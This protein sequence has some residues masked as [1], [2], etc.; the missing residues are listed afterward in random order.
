MKKLNAYYVI[1][2]VTLAFMFLILLRTLQAIGWFQD[3]EQP[4]LMRQVIQLKGNYQLSAV[5]GSTGDS[6]VE[7]GFK[8]EDDQ[9]WMNVSQQGAMLIQLRVGEFEDEQLLVEIFAPDTDGTLTKHEACELLISLD[10]KGQWSGSTLGEF[11]EYEPVS[12]TY[13]SMSF[14]GDKF[15]SILIMETRRFNDQELLSKQEYYLKRVDLDE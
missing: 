2:I 11:C 7:I 12:E 1:S 6:R 13:R 4:D 8:T 14:H 9:T 15:G 10:A 5:D 3:Q